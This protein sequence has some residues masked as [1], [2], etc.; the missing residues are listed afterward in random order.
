MKRYI[1]L[2][3]ASGTSILPVVSPNNSL[4]LLGVLT[5]KDILDAYDRAMIKKSLIVE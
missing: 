4:Q 3:I 1:R 5:R 2:P